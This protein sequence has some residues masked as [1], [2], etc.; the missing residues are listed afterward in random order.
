MHNFG[1]GF[2]YEEA[3]DLALEG[4]LDFPIPMKKQRSKGHR[5]GLGV[6]FPLSGDIVV[7]TVPAAFVYGHALTPVDPFKGE[8]RVEKSQVE[9][10][11]TLHFIFLP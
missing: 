5:K 1:I 8:R 4:I 10:A 2:E 7:G 9:K 6:R 3:D 11:D